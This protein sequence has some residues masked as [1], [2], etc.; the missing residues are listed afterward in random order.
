MTSK[1]E[2]QIPRASLRNDKQASLGMTIRLRF[3][4]TSKGKSEKQILRFAQNDSGY[5]IQCL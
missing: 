2:K 1:S 3:G 4:M 5:L